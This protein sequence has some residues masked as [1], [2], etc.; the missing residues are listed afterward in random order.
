MCQSRISVVVLVC[1][2]QN[3]KTINIAIYVRGERTWAGFSVI[4]T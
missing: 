2:L 1:P 4:R 3:G